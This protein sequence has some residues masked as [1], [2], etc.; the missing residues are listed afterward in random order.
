MSLQRSLDIAKRAVDR[1]LTLANLSEEEGRTTRTFLTP[2]M[3]EAHRLIRSWMEDAG[4]TVNVDAIGNL[5]AV[6]KG[7]DS[8][9]PPLLMGSHLDTVPGAGAFDGLVDCIATLAV[10]HHEH[11]AAPGEFLERHLFHRLAD[12][13]VHQRAVVHHAILAGVD[14]VVRESQPRRD[15]VRTGLR[16]FTGR[17]RTDTSA[18]GMRLDVVGAGIESGYP[19]GVAFIR[20]GE[21][22]HDVFR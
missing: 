12:D 5:R 21:E 17:E 7:S 15:E 6:L 16:D 8:N 20:V 4:M 9:A 2:P 22:I 1:C 11:R 14:A 19:G 3:R 10:L 18:G 13:V